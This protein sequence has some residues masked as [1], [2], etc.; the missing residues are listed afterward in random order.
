M[1]GNPCFHLRCYTQCLVNAGEVVV[2]EMEPDRRS[3]VLNLF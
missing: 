2:Q 3:V 1:V